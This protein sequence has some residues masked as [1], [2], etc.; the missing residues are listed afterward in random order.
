MKIHLT[1]LICIL[2]AACAFAENPSDK[3]AKAEEKSAVSKPNIEQLHQH[4]VHSREEE[5]NTEGVEIYRPADSKEFPPSRFRMAYKFS[6]KGECEWM[7]L[8]PADGHHFKPGKWEIAA[9]DPTL[10]KI[11]A[12]GQTKSFRI[13]ELTKDILR[14]SPVIA[15][16]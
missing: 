15:Q 13:I 11:T 1:T 9:D 16:H 6:P 8:D 5:G 4:W 7:F 10:L 2:T 3:T 14:L 12:E